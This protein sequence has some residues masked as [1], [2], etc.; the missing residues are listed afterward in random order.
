MVNE[1]SLTDRG[2]K[3]PLVRTNGDH[4]GDPRDVKQCHPSSANK[5]KEQFWLLSHLVEAENLAKITVIGNIKYS[6]KRMFSW[7]PYIVKLNTQSMLHR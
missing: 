6:I 4:R 3:G 7:V 2:F 1:V 5:Y